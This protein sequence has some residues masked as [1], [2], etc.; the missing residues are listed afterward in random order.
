M[1][2]IRAT[3]R[4]QMSFELIEGIRIRN[5]HMVIVLK[6]VLISFVLVKLSYQVSL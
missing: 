3:N 1:E 2:G 4:L 6:F 5:G